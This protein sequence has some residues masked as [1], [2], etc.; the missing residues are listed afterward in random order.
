MK[1]LII[2][3]APTGMI[4]TKAM[5]PHVPVDPQEIAAD[6][7][8]C[9]PLG[10]SMVHLHARD[11]EGSPTYKKEKYAEIIA[12]IRRDH[13][14][15]IVVVSTSGRNVSEF[16]KRSDVLHLQGGLKPDMASLTLGSMNFPRTASVNS[17]EMIA[18]LAGLMKQKGIKPELEVFDLGMVNYAKYLIRKGLLEPPYYFNILL[19]NAATAQATL[20]HAALIV[21]ELPPDSYYALAGIGDHQKPMNALGVIAADGVRV[22]LEDNIWLD[23]GRRHPATNAELVRQVADLAAAYGRTAA[24]ASE[25]RT[26]L[27]L[28]RAGGQ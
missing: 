4:P 21:S 25:V 14:E 8:A 10:V 3:F 28:A 27:G 18:A 20:M 11:A 9:V 1:K 5:T 7:A 17:P 13:P 22:G 23:P 24:S 16:D 19:G 6:V 12:A 26:M 15:L 2:N